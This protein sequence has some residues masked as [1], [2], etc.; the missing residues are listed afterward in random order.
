MGRRSLDRRGHGRRAGVRTRP[1]RQR[2]PDRA[3]SERA[4]ARVLSKPLVRCGQRGGTKGGDAMSDATR[5]PTKEEREELVRT[6][7]AAVGCTSNG[8]PSACL[9][10]NADLRLILAD[11][12]AAT[13]DDEEAAKSAVLTC[14]ARQLA[15]PTKPVS[16]PVS[17]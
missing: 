6:Y 9:A 14:R 5:E 7:A 16:G 8:P 13:S 3:H 4:A 10:C 1:T 11:G 12:Y 2:I 17:N 15:Q